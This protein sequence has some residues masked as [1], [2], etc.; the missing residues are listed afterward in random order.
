MIKVLIIEDEAIAARNLK[1]MLSELAQS[2]EVIDIIESKKEAIKKIPVLDFDLILMD[3]HL[4]D[5]SSFGI[6]EKI[7]TTKP[8]IFTTAFDKYTL[9]AFKHLSI[10]YLLKPIIKD[11]LQKAFNK[12]EAHFNPSLQ[13]FPIE[14]LQGLL[15]PS[16]QYKSRFLIQVGNQLKS[17]EI[18][19]V[20]YFFSKEKATYLVNLEGRKFPIDFSLVQLENELNPDDFFRI[21]RRMLISRQS[22]SSIHYLSSSKLS[23][24]L[25]PKTEGDSLL[26]M[27]KIAAFK[28]WLR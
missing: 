16:Q 21:N 2:I 28:E 14:A 7:N 10:D 27:E 5:G 15:Q 1:R 13:N 3:I 25:S 6:F 17:I 8:I 23:I 4:S 12:Y 24:E 19:Q 9:Q 11:D 20:R 22:I 18:D 26:T